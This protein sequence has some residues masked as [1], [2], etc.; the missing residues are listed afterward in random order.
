MMGG[1]DD[2]MEDDED[3]YGEEEGG[4]GLAAFVNNP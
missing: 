3:P 2:G 1:E 4:S